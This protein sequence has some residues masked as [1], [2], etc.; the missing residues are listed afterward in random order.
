MTT[1]SW[2]MRR[3][4]GRLR[5]RQRRGCPLPLRAH[6]GWQAHRGRPGDPGDGVLGLRRRLR[7]RGKQAAHGGKYRVYYSQT[8]L[9][10]LLASA[11]PPP[12]GTKLSPGAGDLVLQD[13]VRML[14]VRR[15]HPILRLAR[16]TIAP[17][18]PPPPPPLQQQ[19]P[20]ANSEI[21]ALLNVSTHQRPQ[22]AE[23]LRTAGKLREAGVP[24]FWLSTYDGEGDVDAWLPTEQWEFWKSGALFVPVHR[25]VESL[26][27]L[28]KV[29]LRFVSVAVAVGDGDASGVVAAAAAPAAP[30]LV[31]VVCL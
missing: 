15:T 23:T 13:G 18:P 11:P 20:M 26:K 9:S 22:A 4:R 29:G 31:V 16:T 2:Q 28:T 27:Y 5:V 7:Q 25:M 1:T 24:L 19:H 17:P 12:P 6:G 14:F 10:F 30:A 21:L 8:L 3:R